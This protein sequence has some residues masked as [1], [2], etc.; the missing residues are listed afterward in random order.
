MKR[1]LIL[2]L[3]LF[4]FSA[5]CHQ[6]EMVVP[7]AP[8]GHTDTFARATQHY[9]SAQMPAVDFII[10]NKPGADG[11]IA[12]RYAVQ[13]QPNGNSLIIVGTGPFL[14]AKVLYKDI[15][16]DY[17]EFD[18]I[19]PIASTTTSIV[20]NK[21]SGINNL[22]DFVSYANSNKLNC[23]SSNPT[24]TFA[25]KYLIRRLNLP[26]VEIVPYKGSN[27]LLMDLMG[28][29]IDCGFEPTAAYIPAYLSGAIKIVATTADHHSKN[30]SGVS[31][32]Q[33][34]VPE[35]VFDSWFGVGILKTTPDQKKKPLLSALRRMS[36]D[37]DFIK[38][39]EITHFEIVTPSSKIQTYM[40][41]EYL[42]LSTISDTLGIKKTE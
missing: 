23:G 9:L 32:I 1:I 35:F 36:V 42:K 38:E 26:N 33:D 12:G 18:I 14:Y 16:Y 7:F 27:P 25:A 20:V 30:L 4:V 34:Q 11:R 22:Q 6:V 15:G 10:I 41:L 3:S 31:L 2:L 19:A 21:K 24:S 39:M 5:S 17:S 8:G 29:H 28:G 40:D 37:P 13:K